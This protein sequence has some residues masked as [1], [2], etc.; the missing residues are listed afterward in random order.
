MRFVGAFRSEC[1]RHQ[2]VPAALR[3]PRFAQ[4]ARERE[5]HRARRERDGRPCVADDVTTRVHDE[6]VRGQQRFDLIEQ[7]HPV[8][9]I[10]N[11][12]CSRRVQHEQRPVDFGD[13][14]RDTCL[15]RRARRA[16]E[17]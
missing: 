3:R 16:I 17:R 6:R 9:P 7:K 1:P 8:L 13:Q 14:R 2:R 5:Q 15:A 10:R 12:A 11:Q 4:R